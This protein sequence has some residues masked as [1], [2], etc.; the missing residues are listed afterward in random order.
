MDIIKKIK[1]TKFLVPKTYMVES[2]KGG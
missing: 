2:R 1:K